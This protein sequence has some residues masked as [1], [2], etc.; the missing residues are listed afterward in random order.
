MARDGALVTPCGWPLPLRL[1]DFAANAVLS[2]LLRD[3][4]LLEYYCCQALAA[5][6]GALPLQPSELKSYGGTAL[7]ALHASSL[8]DLLVKGQAHEKLRSS[9]FDQEAALHLLWQAAKCFV[10]RATVED[11]ARRTILLEI[12]GAQFKVSGPCT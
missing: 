1:A 5:T 4:A 6:P 9:D 2:T 11:A 12:L 8:Q 3:S 7:C 10:E